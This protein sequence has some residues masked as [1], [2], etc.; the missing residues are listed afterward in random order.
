MFRAVLMVVGWLVGLMLNILYRKR[1]DGKDGNRAVRKE[2][3]Y[4]KRLEEI[5]G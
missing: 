5:F 4:K 3:G 1:L 2:R